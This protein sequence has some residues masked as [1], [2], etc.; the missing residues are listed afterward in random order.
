M[1]NYTDRISFHV[2]NLKLKDLTRRLKHD[3][4][5]ATEWFQGEIRNL[6]T[7]KFKK[8]DYTGPC[9]LKN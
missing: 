4:L 6:P 3:W 2:C 8:S 1:C 7:K 5:L 9:C